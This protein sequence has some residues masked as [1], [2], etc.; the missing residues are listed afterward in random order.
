MKTIRPIKLIIFSLSLSLLF[1]SVIIMQII[2]SEVDYFMDLLLL[3]FALIF[4]FLSLNLKIQYNEDYLILYYP[5][6]SPYKIQFPAISMITTDIAKTHLLVRFGFG[7]CLKVYGCHDFILFMPFEYTRMKKFFRAIEK[8]NP[9]VDFDI[10]WY[11]KTRTELFKIICTKIL[12]VLAIIM[13]VFFS[14]KLGIDLSCFK[15]SFN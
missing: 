13:F 7:Y 12:F 14:D 3:I 9:G 2:F 8:I 11:K 15:R 5:W 6:H 10:W 4:M 1:L